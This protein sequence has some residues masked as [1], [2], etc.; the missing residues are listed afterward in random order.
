MSRARIPAVSCYLGPILAYHNLLD[1]K[2]LFIGLY[3]TR[4]LTHLGQELC[5]SVIS[6]GM[7]LLWDERYTCLPLFGY[8]TL[9]GVADS[10]VYVGQK[11]F[12][13]TP[14]TIY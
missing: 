14:E 4:N 7:G 8:L 1:S 9:N 13:V 3:A 11:V 10:E 5:L 2:L 6:R 12:L